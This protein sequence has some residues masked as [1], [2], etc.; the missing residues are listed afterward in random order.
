MSLTLYVCLLLVV[1]GPVWVTA[2]VNHLVKPRRHRPVPTVPAPVRPPVRVLIQ[3]WE[4]DH[5]AESLPAQ[6]ER[7][8]LARAGTT[9]EAA[10][11]VLMVSAR[12]VLTRRQEGRT[13]FAT[14]HQAV[15]VDA[16][17]RQAETEYV[18]DEVFQGAKIGENRRCRTCSKVLYHAMPRRV[19]A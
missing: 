12:A 19:L 6:A 14:V 5:T 16:M 17:R 8:A 11:Q 13:C 18:S 10:P 4:Q 9:P 7:L 15:M 2:G 3:P 1:T